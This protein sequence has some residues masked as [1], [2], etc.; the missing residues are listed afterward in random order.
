M[1]KHVPV[2]SGDVLMYE[3]TVVSTMLPQLA[4]LSVYTGSSGVGN[5][6]LIFVGLTACREIWSGCCW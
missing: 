3:S 4:S 1:V 5:L 6:R 2:L